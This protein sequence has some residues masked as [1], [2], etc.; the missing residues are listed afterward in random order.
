M[1]VRLSCKEKA[2]YGAVTQLMHCNGEEVTDEK[3]SDQKL[4]FEMEGRRGKRRRLTLL[5]LRSS[6]VSNTISCYYCDFK[7]YAFNQP[8][9]RFGRRYAKWLKRWFSVGVGFSLATLVGVTVIGIWEVA[10]TVFGFGQTAAIGSIRSALIFGF[11][12]LVSGFSISFSN[13]LYV[14]VST[15][16]AVTVHELGHATAAA[17]EGIQME[18]ISV[19]FAVLFPGAL[20]AFNSE[21]LQEVHKSIALRIYCA[22]I[23]HNAVCCVVSGLALFLL[24]LLLFPLYIHGENPVVLSISNLSPLSGYLSRGDAIVSLDG[25]PIHHERDWRDAIA[26]MGEDLK[27][28]ST[29]NSSQN[30]KPVTVY[31]N[32]KGYCIPQHLTEQ[33]KKVYMSNTTSVCP[34]ELTEFVEIGCDEPIKFSE[35]KYQNPVESRTCLAGLDVVKLPKCG[36]A[37]VTDNSSSCPC[38]RED[39]CMSPAHFPGQGWIEISYSKKYFTNCSLESE[40]NPFL[41][42]YTDGSD[43]I[44]CGGTFVFVGDLISLAQ[45]LHLTEYQPRWAFPFSFHLPVVLEKL[46]VC[47]FYTSF[48]LALLNSLPVF[49]LDGEAILEV[50]IS[51]CAFLHPRKRSRILKLTLIGGTAMSVFVLLR[52]FFSILP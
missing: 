23:W 12:P 33:G 11:S 41:T 42:S 32:W 40:T 52:G 21:V 45:S 37:W 6:R 8:L 26:V 13:F 7:I 43:K 14:F 10:R 17:G 2:D 31:N 28:Y 3:G 50:I 49:F 51:N 5:P 20:V 18:Y 29:F 44:K 9:F 35:D 46:L 34:D 25:V 19:F 39:S 16:I 24:P 4:G 27:Q 22:G 48:T 47:T 38:P 1:L 15:L 30:Y 36:K